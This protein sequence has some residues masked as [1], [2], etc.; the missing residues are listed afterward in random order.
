MFA[1]CIVECDNL[2]NLTLLYTKTI[3]CCLYNIAL[4]CQI[5]P[6]K[7]QFGEQPINKALS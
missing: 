4:D 6:V 2:Y 5:Y 7:A 3:Y 1:L